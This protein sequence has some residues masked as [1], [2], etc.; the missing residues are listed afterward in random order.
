MTRKEWNVAQKAAFQKACLEWRIFCIRRTQD[1]AP[2]PEFQD[3]V[4]ALELYRDGLIARDDLKK[5]YKA[6]KRDRKQKATRYG[7]TAV[8]E[9]YHALLGILYAT[10]HP[11]SGIG[12][13]E[14][15][16]FT[17]A[18]Y[19]AAEVSAPRGHKWQRASGAQH[20]EHECQMVEYH[21]IFEEYYE[22]W[23]KSF[24]EARRAAQLSA[25]L[26]TQSA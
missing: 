12:S 16:R 26:E 4:V 5:V 10:L 6:L 20:A 2:L 11:V 8:G 22:N 15:Q 3:A 9:I 13:W 1:L 24:S 25:Q 14:C 21:R 17:E 7:Y 18:C 19:L 23:D